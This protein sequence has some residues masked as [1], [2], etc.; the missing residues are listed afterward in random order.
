MNLDL[1]MH[2]M[3]LREAPTLGV[4]QVLVAQKRAQLANELTQ[5]RA[6]EGVSP[7]PNVVLERTV[8][9]MQELSEQRVRALAG[10]RLDRLA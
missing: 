5:R 1:T 8:S 9:E 2:R 10:Q 3:A 6:D 4:A 7:T